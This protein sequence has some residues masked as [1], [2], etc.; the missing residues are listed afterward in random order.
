MSTPNKIVADRIVAALE[1]KDLLLQV[2]T[3]GL[4]AKLAAGR[5]SSS[6]WITLF[7][8]DMQKRKENVKDK[9]QNH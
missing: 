4:A 6:D 7:S 5:Y 3:N 2:S 1:A 8:M 9:A